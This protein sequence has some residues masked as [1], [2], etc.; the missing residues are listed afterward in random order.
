[1][2]ANYLAN[3]YTQLAAYKAAGFT[4]KNAA[5]AAN[6]SKLANS[7]EIQTRIQELKMKTAEKEA[8]STAPPLPI[9]KSDSQEIDLDWINREYVKLLNKAIEMDDLK[10]GTVILKDMAE[11]NKVQPDP[12][13]NNNNNKMLPSNDKYPN[14]ERPISIQVINH[15]S[16]QDGGSSSRPFAIEIP[17]PDTLVISNFESD[18]DRD[19]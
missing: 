2:Y 18:E 14:M 12:A 13:P 5:A 11:L 3:G 8:L 19:T 1:M 6:A 10:M 17:D 15:E 7:P 9:R 4:C 16:S